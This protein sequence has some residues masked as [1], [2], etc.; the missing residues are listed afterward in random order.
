MRFKIIAFLFSIKM[1][2]LILSKFI[3]RGVIRPFIQRPFISAIISENRDWEHGEVPWDLKDNSTK[4]N[5]TNISVKPILPTHPKS[6][7]SNKKVLF[8]V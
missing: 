3:L 7:N 6:P 4:D 2:A 5:S 8:S 1:S